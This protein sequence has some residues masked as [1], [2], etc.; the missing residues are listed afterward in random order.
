MI[1]PAAPVSVVLVLHESAAVVGHALRSLRRQS[2]ELQLIAVDSASSDGGLER[3]RGEWP[4]ATLLSMEE[5][6][7]FALACD[8]ALPHATGRTVLLLNPDAELEDGALATMIERLESAPALAMVAP[9]MLDAD[10]R[11]RRGDG[12]EPSLGRWLRDLLPPPLLPAHRPRDRREGPDWLEASCVLIDREA[13]ARIGGV[14][15]G[16]FLYFEDVELGARLRAMGRTLA[17]VPTAGA[18]H[19][20]AGGSGTYGPVHIAAWHESASRWISRHQLGWRGPACRAVLRV[21]AAIRAALWPCAF[22][23]GLPWNER[24]LRASAWWRAARRLGAAP[25]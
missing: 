20:G 17:R 22:H 8:R 18:R 2:L 24:C 5:N 19:A 11:E 3:V 23:T 1:R 10:G 7:G 6:R 13:L 4:E 12:R 15:S 9:R 14:D 16:Y 25:S 21:R